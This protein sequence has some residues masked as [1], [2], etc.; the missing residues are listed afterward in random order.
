MIRRGF[1][2]ARAWPERLDAKLLHHVLMV[3]RGR[4]IDR[5]RRIYRLLAEQADGWPGHQDKATTR[6]VYRSHTPFESTKSMEPMQPVAG[7][8]PD[9]VL[10]IFVVFLADVFNELATQQARVRGELPRLGKRFGIFD[11]VL[12]LQM[13]EIGTPDALGHFHIGGV[14]GSSLIQP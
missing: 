6:D 9:H 1:V 2:A 7:L 5:L 13:P 12:D 10:D 3:F 8:L 14:R 4:P 11:G